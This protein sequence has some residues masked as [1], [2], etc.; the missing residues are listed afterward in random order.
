[1]LTIWL[2][3][4]NRPLQAVKAIKSILDQDDHRFNLIVS[5]NSSDNELGKLIYRFPELV[6][7]KRQ[8]DLSALEHI[9]LVLRETSSEYFSLFHDDDLMLQNYVSSFWRAQALF[10]EAVSF[11]AN[12]H[13][14]KDGQYIGL[15]FR[16]AVNY[17]GPIS[18]ENLLLRYFSRHQLGIAPFPSYIYKKKPLEGVELNVDGGKYCDVQWLSDCA[19][20]GAMIWIS[21]PMMVY[22]L[23]DSNDSSTESIRDRLRFLAFLKHGDC[24]LSALTLVNYRRFLYKKYLSSRSG[25]GVEKR[26]KL[27][28]FFLIYSQLSPAFIKASLFAL[29]KKIEV[30]SKVFFRQKIER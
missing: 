22:R 13:I 18:P 14:E 23:H 6:Y 1:M 19:A 9:N 3:T 2:L 12:A 29:I 11:G 24:A 8:K 26:L 4:H 25:A 10:P 28:K 21:E 16:E 30:K 20:R 27:I 5:D 15:S 17:V 7:I